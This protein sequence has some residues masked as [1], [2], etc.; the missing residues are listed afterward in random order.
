MLRSTLGFM[1]VAVL[2]SCVFL[3]ASTP[4]LANGGPAS[5]LILIEEGPDSSIVRSVNN[6]AT[7]LAPNRSDE[8]LTAFARSTTDHYC[9]CFIGNYPACETPESCRQVGGQCNGDC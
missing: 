8:K 5:T 7:L 9:K 6:F 3:V 1:N 4:I 2:S